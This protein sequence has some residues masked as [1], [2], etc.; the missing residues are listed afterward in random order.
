MTATA[1]E[2]KNSSP[3][4]DVSIAKK[5]ILI[6]G[7][8]TNE[9]FDLLI[10]LSPINSDKVIKALREHL[11]NGVPRKDV[12]KQYGVNPG[13]LSIC[14][15]RLFYINQIAGQLSSYYLDDK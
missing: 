8:L 3:K 11:V 10:A 7:S 6:A 12:C 14:M 15:G 2:E 13:Y 1:Y 9:W 5:K 4:V